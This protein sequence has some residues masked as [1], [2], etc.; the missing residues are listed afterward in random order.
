MRAQH[1]SGV[2]KAIDFRMYEERQRVSR[3]ACTYSKI[4]RKRKRRNV[5]WPENRDK[6]HCSVTQTYVKTIGII[7]LNLTW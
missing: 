6:D 5:A 7:K 1:R 4:E 2:K 3:V